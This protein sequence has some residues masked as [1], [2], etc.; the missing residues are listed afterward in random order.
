MLRARCEAGFVTARTE[1]DAT[2]NRLNKPHHIYHSFMRSLHLPDV[3][4]QGARCLA[5]KVQDYYS[6]N[7]PAIATSESVA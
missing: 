7:V 6:R 4:G 5:R 3:Q 2:E 1:I